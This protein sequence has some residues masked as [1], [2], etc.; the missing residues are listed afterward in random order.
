[1]NAPIPAI[2]Q[3]PGVN[4][5]VTR[6][7]RIDTPTTGT[8]TQLMAVDSNGEV[9][10]WRIAIDSTNIAIAGVDIDGVGVVLDTIGVD[11]SMFGVQAMIILNVADDGVNVD[12]SV[13]II[14]IPLGA[15]FT[16]SG[17]FVGNTGIPTRFRNS[18]TGP[19][20]GISLGH[21]IVSKDRAP[22][23]LAPADTAYL[24]EPA[25]QRVFRLARER[26]IDVT[27]DGPYG[28]DWAA[29]I[30]AGAQPM[31]PQRPLSLLELIDEC[32]EVDQGVLGELRGSLGLSFRSGVSLRNQPVRLTLSRA[33]RQLIEPFDPVDD[34]LRFANDITVSRPDGSSAHIESPAIAAGED[35]RY[36]KSL[37][38]NVASDLHLP[39]QAGWRF[40]LGTWPELRYPQIASDVAK[41]ADL[42]ED[43]LGFGVGDRFQVPDPP[44]GHPPDPIDQLADGITEQLERF[45]WRFNF[46]GNP[47][48]PWDTAT[49]EDDELGRL[50]TAGAELASTFIA[51]THT[52]MSVST[53]LGPLW[54]TDVSEFPFDVE[55]A[56]ARVRVTGISGGSSPQTFTV[57]TTVVNGVEKTIPAGTTVQLWQPAVIAL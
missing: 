20:D 28:Y 16:T 22:G 49:L 30:A 17:T 43:V 50:D 10:T 8:A 2:P 32:A 5:Q 29:A 48:R 19:P 54:T 55:V 42:V 38:V 40:H 37:E 47:A 35:E 13:S 7:F 15:A 39:D 1:M 21:L 33:Q 9:A 4:W 45:Q 36:Q 53:T 52:T 25:P 23:W 34:D 27:I 26:G 18:C 31:G 24:N 41:T 3:V 11:D 12:W 57:S 56:S 44:P 6:F 51:G 14:P 46:I